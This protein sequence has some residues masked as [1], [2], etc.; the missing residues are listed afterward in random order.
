M[1]D[2]RVLPVVVSEWLFLATPLMSKSVFIMTSGEESS[3]PSSSAIS[4][5]SSRLTRGSLDDNDFVMSGNVD[6]LLDV[7]FAA[8]VV[9]LRHVDAKEDVDDVVEEVV[10]EEGDDAVNV[11]GL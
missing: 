9:K 2:A 1:T 10:D 8:F 7:A 3:S 4:D 11:T 6:G 5:C